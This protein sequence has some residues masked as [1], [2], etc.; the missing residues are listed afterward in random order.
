MVEIAEIVLDLAVCGVSVQ[1]EAG[2]L[3]VRPASALDAAQRATLKSSSDELLEALSGAD[4]WTVMD[5]AYLGHHF[6]CATCQAAG[7]GVRYGPRCAV[8]R[9]LWTTYT[10]TLE[11]LPPVAQN[12][13]AR[14][15]QESGRGDGESPTEHAVDLD[16]DVELSA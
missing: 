10:A 3:A 12:L 16:R 6:R 9:L 4:A 11:R 7:R 2:R 5:R 1:V 14:Q 13:A 15:H 8:G